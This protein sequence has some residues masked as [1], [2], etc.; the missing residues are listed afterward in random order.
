LD[1]LIR[2]TEANGVWTIQSGIFPEN[3][4]SLRLHRTAGFRIIGT[5]ERVAQHHGQWRDVVLIERRSP[6]R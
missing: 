5:R 1:E 4:A 3:Q 6:S 2:S